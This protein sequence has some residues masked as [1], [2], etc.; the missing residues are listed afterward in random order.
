MSR[1][2]LSSTRISAA[3]RN[4][5]TIVATAAPATPIFST[6]TKKRS[7]AML[8]RLVKI[9]KYSGRVESPTARRT[10]LPM[11]KISSPA[12]PPR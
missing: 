9:R 6:S 5:D 4:W 10:P 3:E 1:V 12:I 2:R 8:R 11:L 7:S